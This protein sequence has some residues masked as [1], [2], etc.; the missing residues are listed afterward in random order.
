[1]FIPISIDNFIKEHLENFPG[2]NEK[3]LRVRLEEALFNYQKGVK[4]T[5]GN[6]IW[7]IGAITAWN[8]CFSCITGKKHPAGDYE[9]DTAIEKRDKYGRRHIDEMD[10]CNINGMFDDD[11]YEINPDS[12]KKPSLC[13]ICLKNIDPDWEEELLCNLNR[14]DQADEKEFKCGAYVKL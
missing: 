5:C 6:D 2:E 4:C 1:M 9:I 12:V 10:P 14:N 11:G 8:S 3:V 13:L 7:V